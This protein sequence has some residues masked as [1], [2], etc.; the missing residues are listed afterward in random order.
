RGHSAEIREDARGDGTA[1]DG[2][3][4]AGIRYAAASVSI[5][6]MNQPILG[7][8][9]A[10]GQQLRRAHPAHGVFA[11][12]GCGG[13]WTDHEATQALRTASDPSIVSV[14]GAAAGHASIYVAPDQAGRRC[15]VCG[16]TMGQT[17]VADVNID[18][19]AAHGTFFDRGE[20]EAVCAASQQARESSSSS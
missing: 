20:L 1:G 5:R 8:C 6:T 18:A 2:E 7:A 19:C 3:H 15:P 17:T 4:D 14:S 9:P 10:C 13:V 12:D 16:G 11:C